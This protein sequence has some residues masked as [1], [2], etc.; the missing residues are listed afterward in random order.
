LLKKEDLEYDEIEKIFKDF[1]VT[2]MARKL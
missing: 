2:P 1:G